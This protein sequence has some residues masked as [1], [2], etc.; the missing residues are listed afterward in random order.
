MAPDL[1]VKTTIGIALE[2]WR[3]VPNR[4]TAE[5]LVLRKRRPS[6]VPSYIISDQNALVGIGFFRLGR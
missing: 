4:K 1:D 3:A 2:F 6:G 5:G